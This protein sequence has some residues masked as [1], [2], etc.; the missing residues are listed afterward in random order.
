MYFQ[1]NDLTIVKSIFSDVTGC[2]SWKYITLKKIINVRSNF[3]VE[4]VS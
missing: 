1:K 3:T 2:V 4:D